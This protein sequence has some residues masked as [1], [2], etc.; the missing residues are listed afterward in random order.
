MKSLKQSSQLVAD[1]VT[2]VLELG[3]YHALDRIYYTNRVLALIG[4]TAMEEVTPSA[5]KLDAID[6][7]EQLVVCAK[8]NGVLEQCGISEEILSS[9][10]MDLLTPIP[11]EVNHEFWQRYEESPE[12]ATDYFYTLSKQNDYIKTRAI[13]KNI[14]YTTDSPYGELEITINLSKPEKDPKEI[15]AMQ[16]IAASDYPKCQLCMENEGYLGRLN[17]PARSNHRIVRLELGGEKWGFQYSPYAYYNEHSIVL[18]EEHRP[19]KIS[20]AGIRRLFEFV[21]QFP[22]YMI[23]S[24]ADLPIVGGS[25]LTHD[26]YQAGKHDFPMSKASLAFEFTMDTFPSVQAGVLNWP[27]SVI[28]LCGK[29]VEELTQASSIILE[30]WKKYSDKSVE[31]VAKTADSMLHHTITPIARKRGTDFEIDL[32]LRDNNV[33]A[34]YPDGIF[35]PHRDVQHIKK[36]NIGL[37]EVMGLAI[38]PPRLVTELKQVGNYILDLPNELPEIHLPWAQELKKE[39]TGED[40]QIQEYVR[41][42]LGKKFT[43][44]LEDAGVFK[45]TKEGQQ[46]FQRFLSVLND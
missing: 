9:E 4:E 16:Q 35:H 36:E 43:R 14:H 42:A 17:H 7:C 5:E 11:S 34:A 25:I 37:I 41:T 12:S 28:R 26:H 44:V 38:L 15:A 1:F 23:G 24:N 8:E 33:S 20:E 27:M 13:A 3:G 10:L 19:M 40:T 6:L 39:F 32:V 2:V 22:E 21:Q 18:S 31:V 45:T 46:A 29:D 30:Q